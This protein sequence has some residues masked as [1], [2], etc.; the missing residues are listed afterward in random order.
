MQNKRAATFRLILV[1]L[2]QLK[3]GFGRPARVS[4]VTNTENFLP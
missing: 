2:Y 1:Y 3:I 4:P